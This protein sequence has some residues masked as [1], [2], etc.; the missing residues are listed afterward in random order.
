MGQYIAA[1]VIT[2]FFL[3]VRVAGQETFA[4]RVD[5]TYG[6]DQLLINGEQYYNRHRQVQGHP[7]FRDDQFEKG[8]VTIRGKVYE[9][10]E[11]KYN[12]LSQLIEIEY[13]TF[14]GAVNRLIAV[15]KHLDAFSL[16]EYVFKKMEINGI[17]ARFYQLISNDRITCYV[18][19]EKELTAA[20][21]LDAYSNKFTRQ[22]PSYWLDMNGQR[23]VFTRVKSFAAL[24]PEERQKEIKKLVR[25]QGVSLKNATPDEIRD[26]LH[27]VAKQMN[28]WD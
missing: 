26:I 21:E 27:T 11:L 16:G 3:P 4:E 10:V 23:A 22:K 24:F 5:Q 13:T 12:L 17:P 15:D 9:E 7:Y 19:W 2:L 18:Y 1:W 25:R 28:G 8:T 14:S 20:G 6:A